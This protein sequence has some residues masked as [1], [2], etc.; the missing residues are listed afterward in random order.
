MMD[1][2][3]KTILYVDDEQ[4]NLDGFRF[5]F[6]KEFTIY[7]AQNT[8]EAFN[9]IRNFP[10]KVVLSDNKM[11]DM[12]GTEF[13]EVLAVSNPDIIRILVTAYADTEAAM[14]AINKGQVYRFITKPWDKNELLIAIENAF[15]AYHLKY[16]N[17]QL[18][19]NLSKKNFELED[20]SF[21][22]MVEVS[23]RRKVEEE[24]FV[25]KN[26]L[27]Q[28]VA[29][30]TEEIENINKELRR[31]KEELEELVKERSAQL[32]ESEQRLRTIS[33][34]LPG[35]A[36]FRGYTK[37]DNTDFLVYTSANIFDITGITREDILTS[38]GFFF[39]QV[40]PDDIPR[41]IAARKMAIENSKILDEEIRFYRKPDDIRWLHLRIL[42]KNVEK[43]LIWW[44]GYVIDV[45]DKKKAEFAAKSLEN[46]INQIHAGISAHTGEKLIETVAMK[47]YEVL[48]P[49]LLFIGQPSS[50]RQTVRTTILIEQK[51][52][53]R[54]ISYS[55]KDTPCNL[56]LKKNTVIYKVH[57]KELFP[58]LEHI[59]TSSKA[60]A[61]VGI[62]LINS[63]GECIGLIAAIFSQPLEEEQR[64]AQI[65]EIFSARITAE[66]ERIQYEEAIKLYSDVA[67]NM[68][69]ALNVFQLNGKTL[70]L[71]KAN[72]AAAK[73]LNSSLNAMVGKKFDE[74]YP[75]LR[76]YQLEKT[77]SLV[78]QNRKAYTNEEFKYFAENGKVFFYSYKAFPLPNNC[79]GILFEDITRKKLAEQ[80]IKE[81]EERYKALFEKSP[82]GILL[83]STL[84]D[85]A[86]KIV[87]ANP[88]V[89]KML[90]YQA[91]EIIGKPIEQFMIGLDPEVRKQ[92][93]EKLMAG[94]TL[95]YETIFI[96]KDG[97]HFP[98]EITQSTLSLG[99]EI[100]ILGII[101]DI[102]ELKNAQK[103]LQENIHFL[104]T[105]LETIPLPVVYKDKNRK[106][107][108]CNSEF[109]QLIG[110]KRE[111]LMGKT[112]FDIYP[113][114]YAKR[115]DEADKLLLESGVTQ[116][117]EEQIIDAQGNIRDI[118][119][120]KAVFTDIN[121]EIA[122]Y[123]LILFD[124]TERKNF[125]IRLLET[126]ITTEEKER[127]RF[128]GNLHDEVGPLLSSLKMY[129]S[130][131]AE[132]E[133]KKKKDYI[134][135]QVQNLIKEAIQ[136]VREISNDLSPHILNNYGCIAA[137][138]SYIGL[139]SDFIHI[140]FR[141]NL[142]NRRFGAHL[143]TIIYRITKELINNTLKHA[144]AK[145]IELTIIENGDMLCYY[146]CDD[147]KGFEIKDNLESK[148]GSI[149]L[150]NI[151]SRVKT[152]N[153][154]YH[155]K[156]AP[157]KGFIFELEVPLKI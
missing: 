32:F 10:I 116:K 2:S 58:G 103:Q 144:N 105:L 30:R 5:N 37:P 126:I 109:E 13:F 60:E 9:I 46:I 75:Q 7:T 40:Y 1:K 124:I 79:I 4:E 64:V 18:I 47:L 28:L 21:R 62:P 85:T 25:Y 53:K 27:E 118:I 49:D 51:K 74:I 101:R 112:V 23:E 91:K 11:P 72:P 96:R 119:L 145:N 52:V 95:I 104:T 14:Q 63:V 132:S 22:L 138:N 50:S 86:G 110:R 8:L 139:K 113:Y 106:F 35:G 41:L 33:D 17:Q 84:G 69:V 89:S 123:I 19:E 92:N 20:L 135:G 140:D 149:G 36:I 141:H 121:N 134:I 24:L 68:Q 146:Y 137:I 3:E 88:M 127:E 34:N 142:E 67:E 44:D 80:A 55:S 71:V 65:L 38:I 26:H 155:I 102:T 6:R 81:N 111:E 133:D 152:I 107:L 136:T 143:E 12:L 99:S 82:N 122:G 83:I 78:V 76:G 93:M 153:G 87:S 98:V 108:G 90:A 42:Y 61:Y 29:K 31:Y 66:L 73:I 129:L 94:Q 156:S 114:E 45:T 43:G 15:E 125:E 148:S 100:F 131:L 97:K 16:Q 147:G 54:N 130:L 39:N 77:L 154:K 59:T 120:T 150:L 117:M 115:Y 128:A 151:V 48:Q 157:N 70:T 56:V 57:A